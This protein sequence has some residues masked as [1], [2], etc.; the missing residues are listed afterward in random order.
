MKSLVNFEHWEGH[1]LEFQSLSD[2]KSLEIQN[3]RRPTCQCP[4]PL[5]R[6]PG[7]WWRVRDRCTAACHLTA[8][9]PHDRRPRVPSRPTLSPRRSSWK[10][11]FDHFSTSPYAAVR[12]TSAS[13]PSSA[14]R[15]WAS[16]SI[17]FPLRFTTAAAPSHHPHPSSCAGTLGG[18]RNRHPAAALPAL[19]PVTGE[20]LAPR[21]L[22]QSPLLA[23]MPHPSG[24]FP[25]VPEAREASYP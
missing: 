4:A 21:T 10:R 15:R 17:C 23:A 2:W 9:M 16:P 13:S 7:R 19:T 25:S 3:A 1:R 6:P 14:P 8:M 12:F 24:H 5:N 20:S 22:V 18:A 11:P